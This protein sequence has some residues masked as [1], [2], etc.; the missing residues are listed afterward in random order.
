[1]LQN[2][3]LTSVK[4]KKKFFFKFC[5]REQKADQLN[6]EDGLNL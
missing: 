1:M 2:L 6:F 4:N 5:N 3:I